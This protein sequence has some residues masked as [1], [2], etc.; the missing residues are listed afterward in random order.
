MFSDEGR[1]FLDE[2][3]LDKVG[4]ILLDV[5]LDTIDA[6]R[7][8]SSRLNEKISERVAK[9]EDVHLAIDAG[10]TVTFSAKVITTE[11]RKVDP[12]T[13]AK[14]VVSYAGSHRQFTRWAIS[15]QKDQLPRTGRRICGGSSSSAPR[16]RST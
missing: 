11:L 8:Q 6:L 4:R 12:F 1:T 5:W 9:A 16:Q 15:E 14:S 2:I 7:G 3:D 13:G 10:E